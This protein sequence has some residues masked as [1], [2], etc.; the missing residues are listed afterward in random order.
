MSFVDRYLSSFRQQ[1]ITDLLSALLPFQPLFTESLNGDQ[2]LASPPF[3]G[4]LSATP[5][6]C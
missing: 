3:S 2:L 6:L 1:L 5:S 4:A